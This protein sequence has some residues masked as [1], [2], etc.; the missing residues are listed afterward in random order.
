MNS[1]LGE[2]V[3]QRVLVDSGDH[4]C[5][6]SVFEVEVFLFLLVGERRPLIDAHGEGRFTVETELHRAHRRAALR[7]DL[8]SVFDRLMS[9]DGRTL[10][11]MIWSRISVPIVIVHFRHF[12]LQFTVAVVDQFQVRP[13]RI[14]QMFDIVTDGFEDR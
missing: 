14:A 13:V 3:L 6:P 8:L 5:F 1:G 11:L 7:V 2:F 9:S 10:E 4:V 12:D